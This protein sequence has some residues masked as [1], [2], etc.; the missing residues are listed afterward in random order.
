VTQGAFP[1][2]VAY[3]VLYSDDDDVAY[4]PEHD[5]PAMPKG[6]TDDDIGVVGV[7][8]AETLV[9]GLIGTDVRNLPRP[10]VTDWVPIVLP[11]RGHCRK[12]LLIA[13]K[14]PKL[15]PHADQV[16]T[17]VELTPFHGLRSPLD[18][19]AIEIVFGHIFQ[20]FCR[21]S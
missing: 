17:Q 20:A 16:T 14:Q 13:A 18:F 9:P 21:M 6:S 4:P 7:A 19:V 12:H 1:K 10:S 2:I 3:I 11:A 15:V 5:A 8:S